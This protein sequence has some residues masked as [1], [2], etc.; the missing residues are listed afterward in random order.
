MN[1][2]ADSCVDKPMSRLRLGSVVFGV[3][4][5]MAGAAAC[6]GKDKKKPTTPAGDKTGGGDAEGM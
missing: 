3:L 2:T 6:G 1:R 4:V 5:L